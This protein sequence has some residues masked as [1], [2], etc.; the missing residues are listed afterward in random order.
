MRPDAMP[1]ILKRLLFLAAVVF[2]QLFLAIAVIIAPDQLR[3]IPEP[4]Y[5][6]AMAKENT[7]PTES[8]TRPAIRSDAPTSATLAQL[9]PSDLDWP[10][11]DLSGLDPETRQAIEEC[12]DELF[13]LSKQVMLVPGRTKDMPLENAL[14]EFEPLQGTFGEILKKYAPIQKTH[15]PIIEAL[16]AENQEIVMKAFIGVHVEQENW[17]IAGYTQSMNSNPYT[18]TDDIWDV[19]ESDRKAAAYYF[20]RAGVEGRLV[21]GVLSIQRKWRQ[22]TN[23]RQES[24]AAR[25][26]S[27]E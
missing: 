22:L 12:S 9:S 14:A 3:E 1:K 23:P 25:N 26:D 18:R 21:L 20:R 19:S 8:A 11:P 24:S 2:V 15:P 5:F 10:Q 6:S 16:L 4:H 7:A 13:E 17:L 27:E